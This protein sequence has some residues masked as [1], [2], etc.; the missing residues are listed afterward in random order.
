MISNNWKFQQTVNWENCSLFHN[1]EHKNRQDK[2]RTNLLKC[3]MSIKKFV[4]CGL[5]I[6][7]NCLELIIWRNK[8]SNQKEMIGNESARK[9]LQSQSQVKYSYILNKNSFFHQVVSYSKF[10]K[11]KQTLQWRIS[12]SFWLKLEINFVFE[13]KWFYAKIDYLYR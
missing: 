8:I 2:E 4:N 7:R 5:K 12:S 10:L 13:E 1:F 6:I 9:F 3:H 11:C